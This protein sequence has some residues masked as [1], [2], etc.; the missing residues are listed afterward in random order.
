MKAERVKDV[1]DRSAV[2]LVGERVRVVVSDKG[3]MISELSYPSENGWFNTHWIPPFR[4]SSGIPFDAKV[5]SGTWPVELLYDLAGNFPCLPN[6]GGPCSAYEIEML[7]HGLTANGRWSHQR[8]GTLENFAYSISTIKPDKAY[9]SLPLVSC[10][11]ND[12]N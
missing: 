10:T 3:A 4:S 2:L 11:T 5:H 12:L 8:C 9:P 1:G 7:P 6:F